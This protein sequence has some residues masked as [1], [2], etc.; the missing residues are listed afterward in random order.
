MDASEYALGAVL[1]QEQHPVICISRKLSAAEK[2]YSQVQREALAIHWAVQRLHKYL[3][4]TKFTIVTDHKPL[5]YLLNPSA[6]LSKATSAMIQRWALHLST[7][8][9]EIQHR[10][11]KEIPQ[12]DYLS[13]NALQDSKV[14]HS[15]YFTNPLPVTRD[16]L[17]EETRLAYG[18][19]RAALRN[20]WSLSAR[21]RFPDLFSRRHDL[22]LEADGAITFRDRTLIPPTSRSSLLQHLHSGHVGRDKMISLS[23]FLCWWP[24]INQ[25]INTFIR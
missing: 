21:K 4:G 12:A 18:P 14:D 25:D 3:F 10:P 17:L 15:T 23:R 16:R 24:S 1:E 11:G 2:N 20:G 7:Y 5:Q 19:V 22:Q 9:Y 8:D 6:S 13:R